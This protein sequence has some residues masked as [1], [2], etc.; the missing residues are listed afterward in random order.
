MRKNRKIVITLIFIISVIISSNLSLVF[1]KTN[2]NTEISVKNNYIQNDELTYR[3]EEDG[4]TLISGFKIGDKVSDILNNQFGEEYNIKIKNNKGTD[5]TNQINTKIGTGNK[6]E[7]Y[8][9]GNLE[10][11]YTIIIYGDTN[12][13]SN[14]G[15][16]DALAIIKNKLETEK[17][18]SNEYEEAGRVKIE[19]RQSGIV[20]KSDDALYIIKYKLYSEQYP[21][22][23]K[24]IRTTQEEKIEN[25]ENTEGTTNGTI[26][27]GDYNH[28]NPVIP[29]GFETVDTENTNWDSTDG[30]T[31]D[32]WNKGLVIQDKQ[33]NQRLI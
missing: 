32:D 9:N 30:E 8:S 33:G 31:V 4:N 7:L 23:Q 18:K 15:A 26:T 3:K 14:I 22:D 2:Y 11:I 1:A 13:D 10:K 27:G 25:G 20:P 5:I 21:I 17:F 24:M 19:T 16:V 29:S 12:G 28:D 6:I